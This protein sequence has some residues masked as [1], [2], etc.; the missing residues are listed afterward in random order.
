MTIIS[1]S[2]RTAN[3]E[4]ASNGRD[5]GAILQLSNLWQQA[6]SLVNV[7]T[8]IDAGRSPDLHL[9]VLVADGDGGPSDGPPGATA[10]H[11][12]SGWNPATED[13]LFVPPTPYNSQYTA[14]T[15]GMG[16]GQAQAGSSLE[17]PLDAASLLSNNWNRWDLGAIDWAHPPSSLP[18]EALNAL[19]LVESNPALLNAIKAGGDNGSVDGPITRDSL[20]KFVGQAGA[21]LAQATKDFQAWQ[22]AN[23][24][25]DATATE[26]ARSAAILEANATLLSNAA[27][28]SPAGWSGNVFGTS[29]LS[30]LASNNPGLSPELKGAAKL[31]SDPG[32][33]RQ[34]DQAGQS[35]LSDPDGR[36]NAANIGAW[37][38]SG[39]PGGPN[40]VMDF[41]NIVASRDA[42]INVDTSKLTSDVFD[43]PKNYTAAQKAAVLQELKDTQDRLALDN[44]LQV[45]DIG[46]QT[47]DGINPN[48]LKTN[49]DLQSKIDQLSADPDVQ[50]YLSNSSTNALQTLVNADP[51]LKNAFNDAS[52][53][54]QSGQTLNDD[55]AAKDSKGNQVPMGDALHT[56][57]AQ[58]GFFQLAM[59]QNGSPAADLDLNAIARKSGS[60]DKIAD[61][62]N[63]EIVSGKRLQEILDSGADPINA[64]AQFSQEVEAFGNVI[65]PSVVKA[66]ATTLQDNFQDVISK[67]TFESLTPAELEAALGDGHG[68]LDENKLKK[69]ITDA[70]ATNSDL[71]GSVDDPTS[72]AGQAF[73]IIKS[74]WD[75]VRA[76]ERMVDV[77]KTAGKMNFGDNAWHTAYKVGAF[78]GATAI[79]GGIY[80]GLAISGH[81]PTDPG[82]IIADVG[83]GINDFGVLTVGAGRA[84]RSVDS[85]DLKDA[86][87]GVQAA[88]DKI[89]QQDE[90]V[91]AKDIALNNA[92]A[93]QTAAQTARK[94]AQTAYNQ[95][96]KALD[97]SPSMPDLVARAKDAEKLADKAWQAYATNTEHPDQTKLRDWLD[98]H[99]ASE[100][101]KEELEAGPAQIKRA[102]EAAVSGTQADLQKKD[103]A[104][105]DATTWVDKAKQD[106]ATA[107]E[108]RTSL[109][110]DLK[111]ANDRLT[112]VKNRTIEK[113]K[114]KVPASG[115]GLFRQYGSGNWSDHL[116]P[117][118]EKSR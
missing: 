73:H 11:R 45:T 87:Q 12:S 22:K 13:P 81:R 76:G 35:P 79:F 2:N 28:S 88:Q 44:Q 38:K 37:L 63:S 111:L 67:Y 20:R 43:H 99:A 18:P 100:K 118:S 66:N 55:L 103:S 19:S 60:Y 65:D 1:S 107:T 9:K 57:V 86:K 10:V 116:W 46:T 62:Y 89:R 110:N 53:K 49:S 95:A 83:A 104:L 32:M 59:G 29:D 3:D 24:N 108:G 7:S 75:G 17:A 26:L 114:K 50:T 101:A 113:V 98:K 41:F 21:D 112:E 23:P 80:L 25:A 15:S 8:P 56:Y 72:M 84:Y 33:L 71:S 82:Q 54:F 58:A 36:V 78:H 39:A 4:L 77:L 105:N 42:V 115:R 27:G 52:T 70:G 69:F 74:V 6:I 16:S 92:T 96:V 102:R 68:K 31:W 90:I 61:Y 106:L 97:A 91:R 93:Y 47:T 51:G 40:S 30:A 14:I 34:V 85:K 109:D 5:L 94:E 64:A 117:G 48:I